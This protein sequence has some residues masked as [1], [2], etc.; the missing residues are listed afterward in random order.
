MS[1]PRRL[2]ICLPSVKHAVNMDTSW[3]A[4]EELPPIADPEPVPRRI[5]ATQYFQISVARIREPLDRTLD[6]N[7]FSFTEFREVS[8]PS[9]GPFNPKRRAQVT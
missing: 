8:V 7:P 2:A 9:L 3:L 1:D 6:S 4:P 5:K